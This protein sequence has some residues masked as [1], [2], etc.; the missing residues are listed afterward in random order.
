M[1]DGQEEG[2]RTGQGWAGKEGPWEGVPSKVRPEETE[3]GRSRGRGISGEAAGVTQ[4]R[5]AGGVGQAANL[6][7]E[8]NALQFSVRRAE[9]LE[10]FAY[11]FNDP[12]TPWFI[13]S[14]NRHRS[15]P[16]V[17]QAL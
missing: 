14:F 15:G 7:R 11:S 12:V 13:H 2:R 3:E 17:S 10:S 1:W 9:G 6:G 4:A 8:A 5:G 16:T